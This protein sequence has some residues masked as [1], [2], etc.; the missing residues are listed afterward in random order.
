MS[1]LEIVVLLSF[2]YIVHFASVAGEF[3]LQYSH[4]ES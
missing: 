4:Q 2:F 1:L 3:V